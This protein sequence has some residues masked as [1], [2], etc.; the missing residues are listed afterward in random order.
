MATTTVIPFRPIPKPRTKIASS[1][2]GKVSP[3]SKSPKPIPPPKPQGL[4]LYGGQ[5]KFRN[6]PLPSWS[7]PT[8]SST[9]TKTFSST[10]KSSSKNSTDKILSPNGMTSKNFET[11]EEKKAAAEK[12]VN[13]LKDGVEALNEVLNNFEENANCTNNNIN[14]D[15]DIISNK[16]LTVIEIK[17][18]VN[19]EEEEE[20]NY[21]N[22]DAIY[23][24][25]DIE[26]KT[27]AY[28][29]TDEIV[30]ESEIISCAEILEE[31]KTEVNDTSS[32]DDETTKF[33]ELSL[34]I[35]NDDPKTQIWHLQTE[36]KLDPG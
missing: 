24:K 22:I 15:D 21:V 36:E 4:N 26:D 3:P 12:I 25:P 8:S 17:K 2:E 6:P 11:N 16:R 13:S 33:S 34:E 23:K 5:V 18:E 1:P 35:N 29:M 10:D 14:E 32:E 20:P 9:T 28:L 7:P 27:M 19:K 30:T 31:D